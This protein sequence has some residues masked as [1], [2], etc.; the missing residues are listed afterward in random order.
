MRPGFIRCA[1]GMHPDHGEA[2]TFTPGQLLPQWAADA[3]QDQ[4]PEPSS[5][6]IYELT[7][8][9]RKK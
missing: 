4:R 7:N 3:L 5:D 9:K 2:V 8:T 6:G 1:P